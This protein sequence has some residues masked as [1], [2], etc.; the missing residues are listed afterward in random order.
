WSSAWADYDNDGDMDVF[1]GASS[2]QTG[3]HKLM[4]NNNDGTFTDITAGSGFDL[5]TPTNIENVAHDFN[6]DGYV[7]IFAGNRTVMVNNGSMNFSPFQIAPTHGPMGD[8]NNDGF[9]DILNGNVLYL[10]TGNTN[11]WIKVLLQGVESNRSGIGAR[12]EIYGSWGKQIR[13]VRSGD[14][15][16]YMSSLNTHFGIG[17]A[18]LIEK[19]VVKWPSGTVD[20]ILNPAINTPLFVLEGATLSVNDVSASG[21]MVYPNPADDVLHIKLGSNSKSQIRN[22]EIFDLSGRKVLDSEVT[23]QSVSVKKLSTGTYILLLKD[24]DGKPY[25]QKFLKK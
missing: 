9:L 24:T 1:I 6:N 15:F 10:H 25:S 3:G 19:V 23:N 7:D 14:G 8:V 21:F 11:N 17:Q 12:V 5:F 18:S 13:D 4:R 2:F 22:A 20:T 16:A